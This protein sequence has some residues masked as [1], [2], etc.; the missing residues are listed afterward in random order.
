MKQLNKICHMSN[1]ANFTQTNTAGKGDTEA[2]GVRGGVPE[3]GETGK[4]S[5]QR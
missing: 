5:W 2:R 3:I 4:A 1:G